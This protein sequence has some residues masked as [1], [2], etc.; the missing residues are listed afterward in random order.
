MQELTVFRNSTW[1]LRANVFEERLENGRRYAGESYFMPNDESEQTRLSI[2]H[3]TYLNLLDGELTMARLPTE[4]KRVLDIGTGPG[5]WAIAIGERHTNA[6]VIAT[7]IN[8]IQPTSVPPNV[9]FQMDD[10]Q[11]IWTYTR[12]FDF[13]HIRGL[14]GAFSQW[15][16]VYS[17]S[18][19]HLRPGGTLEV[20]DLGMPEVSAHLASPNLDR[21]NR[22]CLSAADKAGCSLGLDH[23]QRESV[24]AAGLNV[25]RSTILKV[26]LGTWIPDPEKKSAGK[27]A[28][29]AALEGLEAMSLR[30]L[31]REL[32]WK[33]DDVRDLCSKVK[34]EI[35][36]P[37]ARASMPCQFVVARK[38]FTT[39]EAM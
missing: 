26:P 39:P 2:A 18:F 23:L 5:D 13:I 3:Q 17:E 6:E 33:A 32:A 12:P 10:A 35:M 30:L 31:T 28:L 38:L 27:M 20:V 19:R 16:S 1:S 9:F 29:I 7:D 15:S 25:L 22:A 21:F 34:D 14:K 36:R 24:E 11:E 4:L 8:G 37:E